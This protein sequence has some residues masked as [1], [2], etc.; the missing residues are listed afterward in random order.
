MTISRN[1][2]NTGQLVNST[3]QVILTTGVTGN[4]PVTN[5]NSGTSASSSTFWRGDGTWATPPANISSGTS[6]S[7]SG[8]AVDFT[9]LPSSV[10]RI[11]VMFN[12]VST[13]GT[14]FKLVQLGTSGGIQSSGY[15]STS[16]RANTTTSTGGGS[17]TLGFV[18]GNAVATDTL[19]GHMVITLFGSNAWISSSTMKTTTVLALFGAGSVN[20]GG[21]MDR[22]RITTVNGTDNFDAGSI[23]ILYE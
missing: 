5:L 22:V 21:T 18:I 8:T 10:K 9:G 12:E 4:L 1:L 16:I 23:N 3:G 6:V 15:V 19:S 2:A 17:S 11:T 7:A 13:T 14:S 20:L